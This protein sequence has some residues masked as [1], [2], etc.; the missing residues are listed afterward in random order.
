MVFSF[1][2]FFLIRYKFSFLYN[3]KQAIRPL[4]SVVN[5]RCN[6]EILTGLLINRI[7]YESN[8]VHKRSEN[9]QY[10]LIVYEMEIFG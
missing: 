2:R 8:I 3:N 5:I 6:H 1:V 9:V 10:M 4:K 7:Y